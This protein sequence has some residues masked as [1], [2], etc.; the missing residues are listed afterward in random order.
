M[1]V[2]LGT[3]QR[4]LTA[5]EIDKNQFSEITEILLKAVMRQS[6]YAGQNEPWVHFYGRSTSRA[7]RLRVSDRTYPISQD[8]VITRA[9]AIFNNLPDDYQHVDAN[10]PYSAIT[11]FVFLI[12]LSLGFFN[13]T[14]KGRKEVGQSLWDKWLHKYQSADVAIFGHLQ[15]FPEEWKK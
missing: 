2:R 8:N 13:Y 3:G 15:Y 14:A 12:T 9:H 4:R 7:G 5:L 1:G 11:P 6:H 10:T